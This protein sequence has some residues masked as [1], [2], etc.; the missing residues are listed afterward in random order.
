LLQ[1]SRTSG[2]QRR[3][4]RDTLRRVALIRIAQRVGIPLREVRAVLALLPYKR[5]PNRADRQRLSQGWQAEL[6][7]RIRH[8]A[9]AA[10]RAHRL[11][12]LRLHVHRPLLPDQP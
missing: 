10:Q 12:R 6:D 3:Y 5:T 2:N 8:P 9:T 4:R 11:H 7:E 1:S